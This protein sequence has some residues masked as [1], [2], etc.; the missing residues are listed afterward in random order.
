MFQLALERQAVDVAFSH[1]GKRLAVLSETGISVYALNL[2]KRPVPPPSLVWK[3][4]INGSSPGH[5]PRHVAFA[6]DEKLYFLTDVWDGEETSIW[7]GDE[8]GQGMGG[9]ATELSPY[10][11]QGKIS[12]LASDVEGKY[13]F[14]SFQNGTLLSVK[15]EEMP[16]ITVDFPSLANLPSF[17][18][19][20][21]IAT[22]EG[23]VSACSNNNLDGY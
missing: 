6:S 21:K 3:N 8:H 5:C 11:E 17:A 7:M 12:S 4:E 1:S 19:E 9:S 20:V 10:L 14:I 23:Q 2:Q 15:K 16:N 13:A 18:P 22:V